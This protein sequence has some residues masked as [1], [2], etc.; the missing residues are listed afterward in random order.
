MRCIKPILLICFSLPVF[1]MSQTQ[2]PVAT[3]KLQTLEKHGQIRQDPYY[4]LREREN[5]DVI[6]YLQAENAYTQSVAAQWRI[7]PD[8]LFAEMKAKVKEDDASV[9]YL[10]GNY[11]Y[12]SRYEAG[13]QYPIYARKRNMPN[14]AEEVLLNAPE[15]AQEHSFFAISGMAVSTNEQ[16]LT[17]ATD[18]VGRR[19]YTIRFKDLKTGQ[20]LP[21][22]IPNVTANVVWAN[23]NRTVFYTRQDPETLRWY[24]V[25]KHELGSNPKHDELVFEEKD[26]TFSCSVMKTKSKRFLLIGTEQTMSSEYWY[27]DAN[28]VH[29]AFQ[30][31][32]PRERGL[33]YSVDEFNE[34]FYIRT[35]WKAQN[36]RLMSAAVKFPTKE[37]WKEVIPNRTDVYLEDFEMFQD[38]LVLS[39]RKNG[40]LQ[41]RIRNWRG[42]EHYV[43][44]GEPAYDAWIGTNLNFDAQTLRFGY[45][46]L[47]TPASTF[48][49]N[50]ATRTKTLLKEQPVLGGFDKTQYVTERLY[51]T[52]KDG[53]KIPVS[54]V[55]RKDLRKPETGQPLLL[56]AY[57][58]YGYSTDPYFS[59]ANLSLLD[60]GFVY[61]IA[62]VRGGQEMGRTWYENGKLLQKKNTFTDFIDVAELLI[63][64]KYA[65]PKNVFAEGGSAG[66]LLMGAVVNM[67]PDLWKGV[68]AAVP[69]VDVITTMLDDTIPLTTSEY[70]EW[71]NPNDATYYNY[72]LSYSPYD[73]VEAKA[74]PNLLVTAGLHD[75]QVQYWEPAKWVAKL[76]T[77]KTDANTL[78]LKT[79][80]DA[81]HGGAS[82]RFDRM[83]E[84]AFEYAFLLNLAGIN[85]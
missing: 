14:A 81:G 32:Q 29:G 63:Q 26:D 78:L 53:V 24:Q 71:G 75:S 23:D 40:L 6:S 48:D 82:G 36:F 73:Q 57:G 42:G 52:A 62:H 77:T 61:A 11:W 54:L 45:Q 66:G 3:V 33:E 20:L 7:Q 12:Y 50:M 56:Y 43:D 28:F 47:T 80:M 21:D 70:D 25:Y 13:A 18:V 37:H 30:V 51:A 38:Y 31:I 27:L 8:Q 79:N 74:Y 67:R 34:K 17:F 68:I 39:E 22:E 46:S 19:Q 58:S 84:T 65:D 35:N 1:V 16:M 69:F 49:Y 55:Y 2:P 44:F 59:I 15:M 41:L 9:P 72:M 83:K 5:P 4:W 10:D 60:R 64:Q 76:R 85:P